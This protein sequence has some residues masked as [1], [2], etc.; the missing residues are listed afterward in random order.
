MTCGGLRLV[1]LGRGIGRTG[2]KTMRGEDGGGA[3][4]EKRRDG[5][6]GWKESYGK[7]IIICSF[8]LSGVFPLLCVALVA[9]LILGI[10]MSCVL[11]D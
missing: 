1:W 7:G 3:F 9:E 6:G 10:V 11:E 8:P 2:G 4:R 5:I